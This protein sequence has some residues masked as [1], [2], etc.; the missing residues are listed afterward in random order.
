MQPRFNP[1]E[2]VVV[3]ASG[4]IGGAAVDLL[5]ALPSVARVHAWSRSGRIASGPKIHPHAI[6]ITDES[7][8]TLAA[9]SLGDP[10]DFVLVAT[11]LLQD[12][13]GFQ[14]EKDWRALD[15]DRL[16]RAYQVNAIG[17]ALLA[18]HLL[19]RFAPKAPGVFGVISARVGSITDNRSGGWYG[20][21]A[22][23]AGLNQLIRCLAIEA[24]RK[25]P[26][27]VVVGLQ[28]GTVRTA[29]SAPFRGEGD[30]A[31]TPVQAAGHL[32][33]VLGRLTPAESGRLYAW[34]GSEIPA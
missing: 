1:V 17:P 27:V 16:A 9:A 24:A 2:V 33:A 32:I 28:P 4:G 7:S 18:K 8:I 11:G 23:K 3:G 10:P 20:Y 6:D 14:P 12:G 22:A 31:F 5:A 30:P 26:G 21:R 25:R 29:L 34:D 15:A 13:P 19:P